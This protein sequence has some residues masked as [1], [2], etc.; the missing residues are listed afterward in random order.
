[1]I[2]LPG[3][4]TSM[5]KKTTALLLLV[6]V[7]LSG[8]GGAGDKETGTPETINL[9]AYQAQAAGAQ[10]DPVIARVNGR[11]IKKSPDMLNTCPDFDG[12]LF[13]VIL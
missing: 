3:S 6:S 5:M 4:D 10:S 9:A 11:E 1:M 8:C 13:E 12:R 7:W 2:R